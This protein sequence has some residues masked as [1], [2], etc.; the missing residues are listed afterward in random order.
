M[1]LQED[2]KMSKQKS[3]LLDQVLEAHGGLE[4]WHQFSLVQAS[5]SSAGSLWTMK[6]LKQDSM[7]RQMSVWLHEQRASVMPFGAPNQRTA[8][9]P[10]RIAIETVEGQVVAERFDPRD[11]FAG[12]DE[13]TP[14]DP[15]HRAY[16]NGYAL[17]SYL[18]M[19]FLFSLPGVHSEEIEPWQEG[20]ELWRRLRVRFPADIATHCQVQDFYFGADFLLR[21]HDY[22]VEVSGGIL[23]AQY[24]HDYVAVSGLL[25][26]SKR[27]AYRRAANGQAMDSELLVSI[28]ISDI[29]Y[30]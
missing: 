21:R 23:A 1:H 10:G 18:S 17:W 24:V 3:T 29:R 14:W 19:P 16:F 28:D 2:N 15:L 8:Y 30:L 20:T 12:H 7:S 13:T 26:P 22:C 11:S 5:I 9:S 25:M 27:R 4:R 6:G